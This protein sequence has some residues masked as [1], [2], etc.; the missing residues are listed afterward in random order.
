MRDMSLRFNRPNYPMVKF[1]AESLGL[2]SYNWHNYKLNLVYT[3]VT[4]YSHDHNDNDNNLAWH[5]FK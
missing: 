1:L 2:K 5:D 4:D 3:D